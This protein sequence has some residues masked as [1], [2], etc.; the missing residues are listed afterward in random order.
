VKYT[1]GGGLQ[2]V[3]RTYRPGDIW[4]EN[5]AVS[6]ERMTLFIR[7]VLLRKPDKVPCSKHL[8]AMTFPYVY[9]PSP[10]YKALVNPEQF[11]WAGQFS[12]YGLTKWSSLTTF[13]D[14]LVGMACRCVSD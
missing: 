4:D 10:I 12:V 11:V 7:I 13:C 14:G 5:L 3:G 1:K 6:F 9:K 8:K 2:A